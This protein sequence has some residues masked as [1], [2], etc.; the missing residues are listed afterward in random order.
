M[1][2]GEESVLVIGW[3]VGWLLVG[4]VLWLRDLSAAGGGGLWAGGKGLWA[5]EEVSGMLM[6]RASCVEARRALVD[7]SSTSGW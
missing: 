6:F 3:D 1:D 5:G 4:M 7:Q 2:T